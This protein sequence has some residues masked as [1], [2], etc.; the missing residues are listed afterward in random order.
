M[1]LVL[2]SWLFAVTLV[3]QPDFHLK[4]DESGATWKHT[5]VVADGHRGGAASFSHERAVIDVGPCPVHG[6]KPFTLRAALRTRHGGFST[7]LMARSGDAVGLSLIMG[8]RRGCV[9]FEAW[10]WTTVRLISKT[11]VDDGRWHV[12]EVPYDPGTKTAL[13]IVDGTVEAA[14]VLGPGASPDAHLRLGNNIGAWQPYPGDL[15]EVSVVRRTRYRKRFAR[16]AN[17]MR[18]VISRAEH[19]R[20]LAALRARSFPKTSPL[21]DDAKTWP[22][23]RLAVRRGVQDAIGLLPWPRRA[24]L[25]PQVHGELKTRGCKVQRVSFATW[26]GYRATGWLWLPDPQ[27]KGRLPAIL[28]PHGHWSNGALHHDVQARGIRLSRAGYVVLFVDSV[29]VEDVAAGVSSL[30]AMTWNNVRAIDWLLARD[31]VDPDRIGVTGASGGAQQTMYLMALEDRLAAAAPVCMTSYFAEIVSDTSAHCGCNHP[32]RIEH[33]VDVPAMCAVFHPRPAFFGTV[34]GDWT[35]NWPR[36]GMPQIRRVYEEHGHRDRL[37][38]YHEHAGH[39]YGRP[40]R[41]QVYAFFDRLLLGKAGR[42]VEGDVKPLPVSDLLAL[43]PPPRVPPSHRAMI[44]EHRARRA[45]VKNLRPLAP[46][47]PWKIARSPSFVK[48]DAGRWLRFTIESHDGVRVPGAMRGTFLDDTTP[49]PVVIGEH[50]LGDVLLSPPPWLE[51]LPRV[52]LCDPRFRGAF[53]PFAGAWRRNGLVLGRGEGYEAAHDIACF[54][55][56][57]PSQAPVTL[58]ALGDSGPSALIAATLTRRIRKIIATDLGSLYAKDGNRTPHLPEI[59][60]FGDLP[61]LVALASKTAKVEA[62][63]GRKLVNAEVAAALR[64]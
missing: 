27:P 20:D 33:E 56:S 58:V 13:L 64:D 31:D 49:I 48:Q 10:S 51:N 17:A 39:N 54:V 62:G 63:L 52:V 53:A 61:E 57:L 34:T 12:I 8:R 23:R 26:P 6:T 16:V 55:A 15:D 22:Q 46:G 44:T 37:V 42:V 19:A 28:C 29:H 5:T 59:L 1:R 24:P 35:H 2:A 41:E 32:P 3:A 18:P 50:G 47:L 45:K 11:R 30:G 21:L 7:M 38:A 9:S 14:G 43:G 60:R 36:E 25:A 4:L 40:M